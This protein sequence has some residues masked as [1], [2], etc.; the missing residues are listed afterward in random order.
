MKV[1]IEISENASVVEILEAIFNSTE[2]DG[3]MNVD[4]ECA[5]S[6]QDGIAPCD[7]CGDMKSCQLAYRRDVKFASE[8]DEYPDEYLTLNRDE[9]KDD[10]K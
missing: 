6:V 1:P 8:D 4:M 9:R 2:Y 3:L 10:K 5:C 7:W